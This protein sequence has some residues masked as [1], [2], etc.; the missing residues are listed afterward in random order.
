MDGAALTEM[1]GTFDDIFLWEAW[2]VHR[3]QAER[4]PERYGPETL[5]LLRT[6]ATIDRASYQAACRRRDELLP[7][8]AEVYRGADVLLTPAAPVTAPATTPPVDTP[9]GARE[10][11]FTT[12][13]NLTGAPALVLPCGSDEHGLPVGLQ[14][15]AP[16]HA[17]LALLAAATLIENAIAFDPRRPAAQSGAG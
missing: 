2:Q 7:A 1:A 14:L 6:A 16:L 15:A 11:L 12:V 17:D 10:G 3:S 13:F 5:R 8:A 4:H 9:A